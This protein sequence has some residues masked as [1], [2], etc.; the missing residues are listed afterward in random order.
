MIAVRTLVSEWLQ[1]SRAEIDAVSQQQQAMAQAQKQLQRSRAEID[2]VSLT[3]HA[4][5]HT[6]QQLQRSRAEIDAVR[7]Q[8]RSSSVARSRFNG[9]AP[10]S[11]R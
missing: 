10:R 11:T 6:P 5:G 3:R 1:R 7:A 4:E 2:A 8:V 9:A